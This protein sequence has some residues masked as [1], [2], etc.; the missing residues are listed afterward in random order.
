MENGPFMEVYRNSL[1]MKHGDFPYSHVE[2]PKV[3]WLL[4]E[5]LGLA[6]TDHQWRQQQDFTMQGLCQHML[7]S[8]LYSCQSWYAIYIIYIYKYIFIYRDNII[9]I[10]VY[11]YMEHQGPAGSHR[12]FCFT[13]GLCKKSFPAAWPPKKTS[14]R[15]SRGCPWDVPWNTNKSRR[16]M[17]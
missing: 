7:S 13:E 3:T 11:I 4:R 17:N 9:Y 2:S 1:S 8:A 5:S 16:W 14:L 12:A 10:Y 15:F 6:R